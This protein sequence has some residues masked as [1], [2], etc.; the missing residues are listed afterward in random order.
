MNSLYEPI[1]FKKYEEKFNEQINKYSLNFTDI[2]LEKQFQIF[3][4]EPIGMLRFFF[5]LILTVSGLITVRLIVYL[6]T[7]FL[8]SQENNFSL[9]LF[10][11]SICFCIIFQVL[12]IL[13]YKIFRLKIFRGI[14]IV[15]PLIFL[16]FLILKYEPQSTQGSNEIIFLFVSISIFIS[17]ISVTYLENWFTSFFCMLIILITIIVFTIINLPFYLIAVLGNIVVY[18]AVFLLISVSSY[19]YEYVKR[20]LFYILIMYERSIHILDEFIYNIQIPII[21]S[22][23]GKIIYSNPAFNKNVLD[24]FSEISF[25]LKNASNSDCE[26]S[27]DLHDEDICDK[28]IDENKKIPLSEFIKNEMEIQV[29]S[30]FNLANFP[31][32]LFS[33][34]SIRIDELFSTSFFYII[35]PIDYTRIIEQLK[36]KIKSM[37]IYMSSVAHDFKTPLNMISNTIDYFLTENS[38]PEEIKRDMKSIKESA[39]LI[40]FMV[41]D[42]MDYSQI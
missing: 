40:L 35:L 32:K 20:Y 28:I 22:E 16:L 36:K 11:I 6:I 13:F 29:V 38:F 24:N 2:D 7:F 12:E 41:Q 3:K 33:I 25:E 26:I 5:K 8:K 15:L 37:G 27:N 17:N 34:K 39:Q 30:H 18:L 42:I 21:K 14:L 9:G 1:H 4:N 23:F 31:L 10:I 19:I